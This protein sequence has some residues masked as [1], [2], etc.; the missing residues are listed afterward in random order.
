MKISFFWYYVCPAA[1][2]IKDSWTTLIIRS[3]EEASTKNHYVSGQV[4]NCPDTCIPHDTSDGRLSFI[5]ASKTTRQSDN[6]FGSARSS[7]SHYVRMSS[8]S[9]SRALNLHH[10]GSFLQAISQE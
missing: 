7:R 3:S 6:L 10:S 9:L 8:P 4:I 5:G 1:L 2:S